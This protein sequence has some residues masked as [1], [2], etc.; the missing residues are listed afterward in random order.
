MYLEDLSH[1]L[2]YMKRYLIPLQGC[3]LFHHSVLNSPVPV[4]GPLGCVQ[5]SQLSAIVGV[6]EHF[7]SVILCVRKRVSRSLC[8]FLNYG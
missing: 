1:V 4:G 7:N 5:L 2:M 8:V 6:I 3:R